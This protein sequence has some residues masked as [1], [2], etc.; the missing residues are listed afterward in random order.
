[1]PALAGG[2]S[3]SIYIYIYVCIYIYIYIYMLEVA[4]RFKAIYLVDMSLDDQS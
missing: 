2:P 4:Y 1:M 3:S